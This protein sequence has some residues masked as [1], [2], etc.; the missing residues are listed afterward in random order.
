MTY[1]AK[2]ATFSAHEIAGLVAVSIAGALMLR[3]FSWAFEFIVGTAAESL[4]L[5]A[6]LILGAWIARS[7]IFEESG[8]DQAEIITGDRDYER[9]ANGK[10]RSPQ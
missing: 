3:F 9:G 2:Y 6:A 7:G 4:L 1:R 10:G 8:E 5:L